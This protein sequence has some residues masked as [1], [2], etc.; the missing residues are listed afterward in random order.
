MEMHIQRGTERPKMSGIA[1]QQRIG[2]M[3]E[4]FSKALFRYAWFAS[5]LSFCA[6]L[7]CEFSAVWMLSSM[8][9]RADLVALA[10]S[11]TYVSLMIFALPS[12]FLVMLGG[13]RALLIAA[14]IVSA[15]AI[16]GVLLALSQGGI[17][18]NTML[19][20]TF[21]LGAA[22]AISVTMWQ[23]SAAEL[24]APQHS[25]EQRSEAYS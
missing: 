4:V 6:A 16:A 22:A 13:H 23:I 21:I 2:P 18:P 9:S 14:Q 15:L 12:S 8:T 20:F 17:A 11:A 7:I 10:Q 1:A 24:T 25:A 19:A 5:V 3:R